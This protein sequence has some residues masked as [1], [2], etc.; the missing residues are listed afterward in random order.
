MVPVEIPLGC[1]NHLH[2]LKE[3]SQAYYLDIHCKDFRFVRFSFDKDGKHSRDKIYEYLVE[4]GLAFPESFER[5]F[6]FF[7]K[8]HSCVQDEEE[9]QERENDQEETQN[10]Y[11]LEHGKM[12]ELKGKELEGET[13]SEGDSEI[14]SQVIQEKLNS[15]TGSS[16]AVI[17]E[18]LDKQTGWDVYSPRAEFMRQGTSSVC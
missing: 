14:G 5:V 7:Y 13:E 9:E 8:P 17:S 4:R 18:E 10:T 2:K 12:D 6:A 3:K 16:C 11:K 1:M 15:D